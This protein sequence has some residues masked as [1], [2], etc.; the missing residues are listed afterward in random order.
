[1]ITATASDNI[2]DGQSLEQL[3]VSDDFKS[4]INGG[5]LPEDDRKYADTITAVNTA[6]TYSTTPIYRVEIEIQLVLV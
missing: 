5:L 6:S 1:V 4:T 3:F 2:L